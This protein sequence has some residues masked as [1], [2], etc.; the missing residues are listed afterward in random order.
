VAEGGASGDAAGT[1]RA[2]VT[3]PDLDNVLRASGFEVTDAG[4]QRWRDRVALPIPQVA[5]DEAQRL[6]DRVRS[7]AA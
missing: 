3:D 4:R 2:T 7:R 1:R 6:L 5:L